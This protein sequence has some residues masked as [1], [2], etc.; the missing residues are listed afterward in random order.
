M[1]TLVRQLANSLVLDTEAE[2]ASPPCV[3]T[4]AIC[5]DAD[6]V[7]CLSGVARISRDLGFSEEPET[8]YSSDGA[9]ATYH[10]DHCREAVTLA[11]DCNPRR[12]TVALAVSGLDDEATHGCFRELE[13][14]LFGGC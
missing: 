3:Y 2:P 10:A 1:N 8:L 13:E 7:T 4:T 12:R 5:T 11:V 14:A 6:L 9:S